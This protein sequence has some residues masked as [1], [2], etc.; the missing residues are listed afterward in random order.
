MKITKGLR[1][2]A[3]AAVGALA[4]TAAA[5]QTVKVGSKNFT[6]QFVVAELYA[7]ALEAAGF[8]VERKL[9]LGT[10][11]V[12]HEAVRTGAIDVYPEYTGTG[13]NAVVKAQGLTDT[14]PEKVYDLVKAHYEKEYALTWLKPSGV[15]NGYAIV[16][17]PET[18]REMNLKS[19]SDLA[20]VAPGLKLGAGPEFADRR[21]GL[22]GMKEVYGLEF[23]EFKQFAALRL[24]YDALTGKQIDVAN[25][26]A[27]DWQIAAERFVALSDDKG[28]FPPY[29]LAPVA[30]MELAGN[31]K[32]VEALARVGALIDNATMQELNRQVEVDKR[33]PRSVAAA[34]LKAKGIAP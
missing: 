14:S 13:L 34:F 27:T 8:K 2:I 20:K 18:A 19:L 5:A 6:E 26:F 25:G 23:G 24:R 12:A 4:A 33:E 22:K 7:G 10:T 29:Y 30:R 9:N 16:V 1:V 28:L 32:A 15:N 3:A 17:R 11:L 21:D 31:A